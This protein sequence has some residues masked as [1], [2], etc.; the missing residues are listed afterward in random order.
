MILFNGINC[1]FEF[2]KW[3]VIKLFEWGIVVVIFVWVVEN[4]F[5]VIVMILGV[6]IVMLV[7]DIYGIVF[8]V[9]VL[10][11]FL[12]ELKCINLE[13]ILVGMFD[14]EKIILGGY[15]VGGRVVIESVSFYFFL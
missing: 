11:V 15:F 5:G 14:L 3:L 10:L 8:I 9:L 7:F 4:F 13:G 12:K 6:N 1:N 2:Y